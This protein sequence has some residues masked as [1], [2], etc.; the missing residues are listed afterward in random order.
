VTGLLIAIATSGASAALAYSGSALQAH[1]A[2]QM[3]DELS[4]RPGFLFGGLYGY[5]APP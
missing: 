2:R 1:E 4:L 3:P 5:F